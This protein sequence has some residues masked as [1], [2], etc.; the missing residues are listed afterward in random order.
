MIYASEKTGKAA[1]TD[2]TGRM[3][4][5]AT[6]VAYYSVKTYRRKLSALYLLSTLRVANAFGTSS[7]ESFLASAMT[8]ID[9][10]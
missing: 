6:G 9:T 4:D 1:I 5:E 10:N 2:L 8:S 7:D 3:E